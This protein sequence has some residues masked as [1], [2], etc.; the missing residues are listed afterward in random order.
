MNARQPI[1]KSS[2]TDL[3]QL[4]F[5]AAP[6]LVIISILLIL[7]AT[8]FPFNFSFKD[9]LSFQEIFSSFK[10]TSHLSDRIKNWL[11]FLPLG[12]GLMCL[13]QQ[14][15]LGKTA[16]V[17]L[18]LITSLC[19]SLQVE[20]LQSFLPSRQPTLADVVNNSLGGLLGLICFYVW[21]IKIINYVV[22][23]IKKNR[24]RL[25][26]K[27]LSVVFIG[28]ITLSFISTII[29]QTTTSLS[30]WNLNFPLILGNE[31]TGD[32]PWQ[33]YISEVYVADRAISKEEVDKIFSHKS[34]HQLEDSLLAHY[35]LQGQNNYTDR[36]G[37]LPALSWQGEP[38]NIQD[39]KGV[40]LTDN[41]WL[42][43]VTPVSFLNQKL[44]K[45]NQFTIGGTVATANT[46]QRKPARIISL[47]KSNTERN[48]TLGQQDTDLIVRLRTPI[49]GENAAYIIKVIP[50]IFADTNPHQIIITYTGFVLYVY[51]DKLQNLYSFNLFEMLPKSDKILYYGLIFIPL[52][53]LLEIIT[54]LSQKG[55]ILYPLLFAGILLPSLIV[56]VILASDSS[57]SIQLENFLL[58]ILITALT[59]LTFKLRLPTWLRSKL[60]N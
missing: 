36:T 54:T 14:R 26:V 42:K 23:I 46:L 56:E 10:H 28:Y 21:K 49:S 5:K 40:F 58:S 38:P 55:F 22:E 32:R 18:V 31:F 45:S 60:V 4:V 33:G 19:L 35:Q 6:F 25:S 50:E 44:R 48:F 51:V 37:K 52:G 16:K 11:L 47:S 43:T 41:H 39:V 17:L 8:L 13:L 30:N 29:L 9:G 7:L 3:H 59:V 57:R 1:N 53:S 27:Q 24:S 34:L 12:F 15:R 20:I 2:T